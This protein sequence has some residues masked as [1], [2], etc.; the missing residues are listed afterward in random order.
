VF[1]VRFSRG[2][3]VISLR[4]KD[5]SSMKIFHHKILQRDNKYFIDGITVGCPLSN[6]CTPP[7]MSNT[8]TRHE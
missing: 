8:P 6:T 5:G 3:Y 1:G 2:C 7:N 4:K